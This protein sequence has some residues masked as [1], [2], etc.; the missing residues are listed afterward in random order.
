[1]YL[2]TVQTPK[3]A[4]SQ[5]T[6]IALSFSLKCSEEGGKMGKKTHPCWTAV[7]GLLSHGRYLEMARLSRLLPRVIS[8]AR[9]WDM[10]AFTSP[11]IVSSLRPTLPLWQLDCYGREMGEC[12]GKTKIIWRN[13]SDDQ[14]IK[15]GHTNIQNHKGK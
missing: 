5:C 10:P 2:R 3:G 12:E 15:R 7:G 9:Y 8:S 14:T 6:T 1:M 11:P 13:F 4:Q